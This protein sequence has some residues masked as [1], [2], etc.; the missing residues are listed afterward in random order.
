MSLSTLLTSLGHDA[1]TFM[2]WIDKAAP[3]AGSVLA[4]ADPPL[5][6]VITGVEAGIAALASVG[7]TP[8]S[9][10]L[11]AITVAATTNAAVKALVAPTAATTPAAAPVSTST[12]AF[13][14]SLAKSIATALAPLLAPPL[15][16]GAK[17]AA[18]APV[19]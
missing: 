19:A 2:G 15:A 14:E 1:N 5:S 8:T 4:I 6:P 13:L 7:K 17:P 12:D 10:D 11:Q 16:P 9:A 18:P 3:V